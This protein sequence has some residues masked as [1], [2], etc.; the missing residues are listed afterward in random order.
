MASRQ[1]RIPSL[2]LQRE[3][4]HQQRAAC[5]SPRAAERI[6]HKYARLARLATYGA[7]SLRRARARWV[8]A[9]QH[10]WSG[11]VLV[12]VWLGFR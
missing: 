1:G 4:L 3:H 5:K 10:C 9:A 2:H 12:M 7:C 6:S 11:F 8:E